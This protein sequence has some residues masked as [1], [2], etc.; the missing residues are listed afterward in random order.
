MKEDDGLDRQGTQTR[1]QP[2]SPVKAT[3]SPLLALSSIINMSLLHFVP[4]QACKRTPEK[5]NGS[6]KM[7]TNKY[8]A[9]ATG[10]YKLSL[11]MFLLFRSPLASTAV[12]TYLP[13]VDIKSNRK[14]N[15]R[16]LFIFMSHCTLQRSH[17]GAQMLSMIV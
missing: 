3:P 16:A 4:L 6:C 17:S 12:V 10:P 2:G 8:L 7:E 11:T 9:T 13:G 5:E 15:M 1:N 14:W